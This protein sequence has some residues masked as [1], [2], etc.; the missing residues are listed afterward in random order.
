MGSEK[1]D[2]LF[3]FVQPEVRKLIQLDNEALFSTTD[4]VTADKITRDILRFVSKEGT[5]TDATACIGGSAYSFIQVYKNVIAIEY[6]KTRFEYLQHNM[7]ILLNSTTDSTVI[8]NT[9][10]NTIACRQ[11]DALIECIKQLQDA[12]FIDPPWGGPEYKMLSSVDLHLSGFPLHELCRRI[13]TTTHYIILKVPV[14]FGEESF[15]K[16]TKLFMQLI[17]K[18]AQLRKMHLLIFKVIKKPS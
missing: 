11:G 12:I 1:K 4:Q 7:N 16:N 8:A 2:F 5:I 9:K 17:H 10:D 13:Y 15:I 3:R 18:N 6:D 14:N